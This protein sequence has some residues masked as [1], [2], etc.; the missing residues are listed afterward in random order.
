MTWIRAGFARIH[1]TTDCAARPERQAPEALAGI[2]PDWIPLVTRQRRRV[3][4]KN[5]RLAWV[6]GIAFARN[7]IWAWTRFLLESLSILQVAVV[8]DGATGRW[9]T[10]RFP[11][12]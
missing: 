1:R 5:C 4:A 9:F 6:F 2:R 11:V 10:R 3:T 12:D 7:Q 8:N